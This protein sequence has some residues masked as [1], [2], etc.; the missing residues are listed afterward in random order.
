MIINKQNYNSYHIPESSD[1]VRL[2]KA[3]VTEAGRSFSLSIGS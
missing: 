2:R 1:D 3:L